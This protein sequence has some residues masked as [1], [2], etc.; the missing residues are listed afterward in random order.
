MNPMRGRRGQIDMRRLLLRIV[1]VC[2]LVALA[3]FVP[4][5]SGDEDL[6]R[7]G[8]G[9]EASFEDELLIVP[10]RGWRTDFSHHE[11]PLIQFQPGG[12][13]REGIPA[14]DRPRLTTVRG[15]GR[16]LDPREPVI[17]VVAGGVA[18]AYPLQI[19]IWHEIVNDT[20]GGLPIVVTYCPLCNSALAFER[21]LGSRTLS[22]G[23]TGNLRQY[24]LVMYDRQT[25]SW[26]QQFDGRALVGELAGERMPGLAAPL[27]AWREF[28]RDHPT[29]TVLSRAT[30]HS[31]P[32]GFNPYV[33][34][35]E[36]PRSST[37]CGTLAVLGSAPKCPVNRDR[38]LPARERVVLIE[39]DGDA[40]ALRRVR[41]ARV[42]VGGEMLELSWRPGQRS[43]FATPDG[44]PGKQVG[45]A[46]VRSV[47]S[48]ARVPASTP[49]WFAV[50]AANPGIRISTPG[51]SG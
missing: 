10:R 4:G 28:A 39:R 12:P 6:V 11:V 32:Y 33:G 18:R 23:T 34:L 25:E 43:P 7:G 45:S 41:V 47:R 5:D 19:L 26:W 36:S 9:T 17:E 51:G 40:L 44:G 50:A 42:R 15:A 22:F 24:N 49:F 8:S 37:E 2:P 16:W 1:L 13:G 35:D 20:L 30:G 27:R 29:A 38:R 14:V 48:G 3:V 31:R 46:E 21:R